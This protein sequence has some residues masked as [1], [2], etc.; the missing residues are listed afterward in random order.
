MK[1]SLLVTG[2][3]LLGVVLWGRG[4]VDAEAEA[5]DIAALTE[6]TFIW[7]SESDWEDNADK[8]RVLFFHAAWCPTCR[9]AQK[10]ILENY[11]QLNENAVIFKTDYDSKTELKE[12]YGITK[13]HTFVIT[14]ENGE[15]ISIWYGG[16]IEEINE[17]IDRL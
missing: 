9:G 17:K 6:G 2:L 14:D 16:D 7:Y 5:L 12:K 3:I 8:T 10:N 11:A 13:Q 1:K 4:R 15:P